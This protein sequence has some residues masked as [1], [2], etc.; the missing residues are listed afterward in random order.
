[1]KGEVTMADIKKCSADAF[2]RM[3]MRHANLTS[4]DA[5][6]VRNSFI[7]NRY[8]EFLAINNFNGYNDNDDAIVKVV[9]NRET[10]KVLSYAVRCDIKGS[11]TG[12]RLSKWLDHVIATGGAVDIN[13]TAYKKHHDLLYEADNITVVVTID[14]IIEE[15]LLHYFFNESTKDIFRC[16]ESSDYNYHP[17]GITYEELEEI[18]S[19]LA[20]GK[21]LLPNSIG[22]T[23][24]QDKAV[25]PRKLTER[26]A[27]YSEIFDA[28]VDGVDGIR[29]ES[30][31]HHLDVLA[32]YINGL[33]DL[34]YAHTND[35]KNLNNT[36]SSYDEKI[37][38]SVD[39]A[40]ANNDTVTSVSTEVA[41]ISETVQEQ[42]TQMENV[43]TEVSKLRSDLD[44]VALDVVPWE[45][46]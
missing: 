10:G 6:Y 35:I 3:I 5:V 27:L 19:G 23:H 17:E 37:A 1:M 15:D 11:P 46:E 4:D 12:E 13:Y 20:S 45:G 26:Y 31:K 9:V 44:A 16:I 28:R 43:V 33:R 18:L 25:S 41:A 32:E 24:I 38:E 30:L 42:K 7:P 34:V 21:R 22:A 29:H 39:D 8:T 36:I 2:S 14:P 40:I